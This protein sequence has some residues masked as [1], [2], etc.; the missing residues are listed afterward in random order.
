MSRFVA[1]PPPFKEMFTKLPILDEEGYKKDWEP[2][3]Q[4]VRAPL[5]MFQSAEGSKRFE[6]EKLNVVRLKFDRTPMSVIC[7]S[8]V[9]FGK[10]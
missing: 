1:I 9:G 5:G 6:P 10:Q 3:F 4:T 7:I 8:S 2:V